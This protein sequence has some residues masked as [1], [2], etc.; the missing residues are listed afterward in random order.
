MLAALMRVA[1]NGW[2]AEEGRIKITFG[3]RKAE[4]FPLK[5]QFL[6]P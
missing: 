4:N 3:N 2:K 1:L 5:K 6:N